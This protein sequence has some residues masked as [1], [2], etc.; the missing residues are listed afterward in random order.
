MWFWYLF[1]FRK[2]WKFLDSRGCMDIV[3]FV[4]MD[5]QNLQLYDPKLCSVIS[6]CTV[7]H[8]INAWISNWPHT[9]HKFQGIFFFYFNVHL[10]EVTGDDC[11]A[12]LLNYSGLLIIISPCSTANQ[13][14]QNLFFFLYFTY[15]WELWSDHEPDEL[16]TFW[17]LLR[18]TREAR[19]HLC[20]STVLI[21]TQ[22]VTLG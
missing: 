3:F 19:V 22:C 5:F 15:S 18:F 11:C 16:L 2:W 6:M 13:W 10:P 7:I 20:L 21:V 8:K 12:R 1:Y 4:F 17:F 9:E 14:Q